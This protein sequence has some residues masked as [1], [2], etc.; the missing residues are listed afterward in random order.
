[1]ERIRK[2]SINPSCDINT[3]GSEKK[4]IKRDYIVLRV[5]YAGVKVLLGMGPGKALKGRVI[6]E[7]V[8]VGDSPLF[9]LVVIL[10]P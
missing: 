2:V 8:W 3:K 4:R 1:V 9:F 10:S 7:K 6:T 5:G